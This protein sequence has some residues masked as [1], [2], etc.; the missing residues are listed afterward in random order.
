MGEKPDPKLADV[1]RMANANRKRRL[2]E[3]LKNLG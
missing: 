3:R 2:E 1:E